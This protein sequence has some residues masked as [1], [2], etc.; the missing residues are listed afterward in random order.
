MTVELS[1]AV[2]RTQI[3]PGAKGRLLRSALVIFF[4]AFA[5]GLAM[6]FVGFRLQTLVEASFDPYY[7][8]EMGKSIAHG[9][10]FAP[11]GTL[12]QRRAPLYPLM[13]GGIYFVF[14][15]Q[16]T[17]VLIAQCLLLAGT[18]VLA[19]DIGRR[20]FNERTGW[21]A[22]LICVLNPMLLRYVGDL[23]LETLLTFLFTLMVWFSVRFYVRPTLRGGILIGVTAGLASLTKAVAL[24][25]PFVFAVCVI[26][27]W[28]L[29]RRG[30][31]RLQL[32]L[33]G[34]I[35]MVAAMFVVIAPWTVRN[36]MATGGHLVL[37]SSGTSDAFLRG[38]IF[39]KPQYALLQLPPYT[40]AENESNALL[41]GLANAA[42]VDWARDDYETDQILN[43]A[44]VEKL[45]A[46]PSEF[47]RKV[48]TGLVT[49]WY[50]MTSLTNSLLAGGL[51]LAAWAL[52]IVGLRRAGREGRPAW[53]LILPALY[54][55]VFLAVLLAL[56]RYSVPIL[57]ALLVV[58]AFGVDTLLSRRAAVAARA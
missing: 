50:Q 54:L 4:A 25:F 44:A 33:A 39:S 9:D 1:A 35:A 5:V 32:P 22:A 7:F 41:R 45:V 26:A 40:D 34:M 36:F 38:Y 43:R 18:C 15:E 8:G 12:I 57:P 16:S 3:S 51:A 55:N 6:V 21:I 14:G 30:E 13:I 49:F 31:P 11:F 2:G 10:G 28:A 42:G 19:F 24:P 17:F 56:G 58:S 23:Q 20:L 27:A 53:L 37:L 52:A 47:V 48:A 46:E 29:R